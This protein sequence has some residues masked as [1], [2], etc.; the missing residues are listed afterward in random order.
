MNDIKRSYV[1]QWVGPFKS[2][3]DVAKYVKR[4]DNNEVCHSSCFTFYYLTGINKI[5]RPINSINIERR[6]LIGNLD[7]MF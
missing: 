1:I 3:N 6:F 4:G 2:D 7:R 5:G